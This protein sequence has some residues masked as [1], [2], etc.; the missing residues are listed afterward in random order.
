[1]A[2]ERVHKERF[3]VLAQDAL[4]GFNTGR[5]GLGSGIPRPLPL[6]AGACTLC[7]ACSCPDAPCRHPDRALVSMEAAGL[8]VSEACETAG[9]PY[10]HGPGTI[11]YTSCILLCTFAN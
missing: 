1:M 11:S 4:D 6:S 10:Y 3:A 7:T 8:M 2:A 9:L 5:Q